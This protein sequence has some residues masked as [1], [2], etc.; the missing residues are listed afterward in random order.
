MARQ[1]VA[2]IARWHRKGDALIVHTLLA[3]YTGDCD[4]A[5]ALIEKA[6]TGNEDAA[7]YFGGVARGCAMVT[8]GTVTI[9]DEA[10]G[11]SIR[12]KEDT[13]EA[14]YRFLN[15]LNLKEIILSDMK[16]KFEKPFDNQLSLL[17]DTTFLR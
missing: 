17:N 1:H 10:A 8:A 5:A 15:A 14:T 11:V 12:L 9:T 7:R 16:S 6:G 4:R 3:L 13:R 2:E